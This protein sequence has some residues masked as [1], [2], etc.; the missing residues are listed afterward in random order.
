MVCKLIDFALMVLKF[1]VFKVCV[2]IA[3]QKS[4]FSIF[5]VLKV[6]NILLIR[7]GKKFSFSEY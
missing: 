5:P 7:N 1:F 2:I 6:L 4:R 3:S